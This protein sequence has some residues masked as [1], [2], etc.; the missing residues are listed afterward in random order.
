LG[1]LHDPFAQPPVHT[2][3]SLRQQLGH[4]DSR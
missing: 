4:A 1:Q 2:L 3:L